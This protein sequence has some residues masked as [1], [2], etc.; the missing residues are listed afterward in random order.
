[1]E[2]NEIVT[3]RR[4]IRRFQQRPI[5]RE[6]LRRILDGVRRASCAANLQRLRFVVAQRSETVKAIFDTTAWAAMV[7]PRRTPVWGADAPLCFIAVTAPEELRQSVLADA[8]A[9]IQTMEYA[10]WNEGIGSCWFG[11]FDPEKVRAALELPAGTAVLYVVA[12]GYP[13]EAP[14][15]EDAAAGEPVRYYLDDEDRL[16]VP[17]FTVDALTEWR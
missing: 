3:G 16:H 11:S 6:L 5:P 8:G 15:S 1:M 9:A 4:T 2:W 17:K 10:A 12:L 14:V 13:A 7:R